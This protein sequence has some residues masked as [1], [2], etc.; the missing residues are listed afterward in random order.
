MVYTEVF[1]VLLF[2]ALWLGTMLLRPWPAL[3]EWLLIGFSLFVIATWGYYDLILFLIILL[4]NF[5]GAIA[6]SKSSRSASKKWLGALIGFDLLVLALFK[7]ADFFSDNL[8]SISGLTFPKFP[9][10][11]PLAISFYTFHLISYLVDLQA[12]RVKLASFRE[13][14][15]YLSFF[16]HVI[17]GPIVRA[18]QLMPQI[19]KIRR[20]RGNLAM[21][22][23]YMVIGFFLKAVAANNI[24]QGIDPIWEGISPLSTVD[25]W[26]LPFLYY[27]QIYGDFAGYSLMALG[28]ARLLGYRLP[29]NFRAPMLAGTLREFWQRWHITLSRWLRDYLYIPL[30]GNRTSKIRSALNVLI[31]MILGGLWHGAGWGFI[32]WGFLHGIGLAAERLAGRWSWGLLAWKIPG[33]FSLAWTRLRTADASSGR[34]HESLMIFPGWIVAQIWILI[35]W[36]FFRCPD[37]STSFHFLKG[38][39]HYSGHHWYLVHLNIA[40]PLL[41]SLPVLAHQFAP[42][43]LRLVPRRHLGLSL[44]VLTG[45]VLLLNIVI[46][47]PAKTFIY[48]R[49]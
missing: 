24:A 1:F 6:L 22:L 5:G 43:F 21:G 41:A 20:I 17:A 33:G 2:L 18:W 34:S 16:P 46:V 49:F 7:Y 38:M 37:L 40:F 19:G 30:G 48:F 23:H 10:G 39:V 26:L 11:I 27:C 45:L 31:T 12:G 9:L 25:Y 47:S 29:P 8:G 14:L 3:K 36:I 15:F 13:Y 44:G 28:M 42:S 4:V 35:A 32:I